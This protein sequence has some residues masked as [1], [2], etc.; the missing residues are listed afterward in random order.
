[1]IVKQRNGIADVLLTVSATFGIIISYDVNLTVL[2]TI[3]RPG[4]TGGLGDGPILAS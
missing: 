2:T 1:M 4:V 3:S